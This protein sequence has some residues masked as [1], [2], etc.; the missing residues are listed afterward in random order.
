MEAKDINEHPVVILYLFPQTEVKINIFISCADPENS[1]RGSGQCLYFTEG[2]MDLNSLEK[3]VLYQIFSGNL[4]PLLIF[5]GVRSP[6]PPPSGSPHDF[7]VDP[8][9]LV[10]SLS[11]AW[12]YMTSRT[13]ADFYQLCMDI[14]LGHDKELIRL[15]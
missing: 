7:G 10:L 11:L 15:W 3:G 1:V 13:T 5:Q 2:R 8:I 4:K 12:M 14:A 9:V 6:P